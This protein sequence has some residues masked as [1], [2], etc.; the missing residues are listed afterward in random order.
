MSLEGGSEAWGCNRQLKSAT[1]LR[2]SSLAKASTAHLGS[3]HPSRGLPLKQALITSWSNCLFPLQAYQ[4]CPPVGLE[5][6]FTQRRLLKGCLGQCLTQRHRTWVTLWFPLP[7]HLGPGKQMLSQDNKIMFPY[8]K[9]RKAGSD[10]RTELIHSSDIWNPQANGLSQCK[11]SSTGAF[12]KSWISA[13]VIW[14]QINLTQKA[15]R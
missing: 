11:W 3:L 15:L 13:W 6:D 9:T 7:N 5:W 2:C 8:R 14:G 10:P 12:P 4:K 1:Q